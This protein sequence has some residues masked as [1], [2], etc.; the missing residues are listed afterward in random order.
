MNWRA[1]HQFVP[2][3][4]KGDAIGDHVMWIRDHLRTRG[5]DSEIF[6][7]TRHSGTSNET[8]PLDK[9][10]SRLKGTRDS[11]LLYHVA[12]ASPC[13]DFLMSR[14][15]PLALIFHNFTPPELLLGWDPAAAFEIL[16]AQDQLADLVEKARFAIC[17]SAFNAR[18]LLSFGEV[19]CSVI[20]LPV[21]KDSPPRPKPA[22]PVIL[23]VGRIAPN[24][25]I[26]DLISAMKILHERHPDV[27]L[28]IVGGSTSDAYQNAITGLLKALGLE[29]SVSLTGWVT[30]E[31][32]EVEYLRA[33]IFCSLSSHEGFG[34]PLV[35][36]MSQGVP[37]IAHANSAI[38]ETLGNSG[39][40]LTDK[41][42]SVVATALERV[43]LD[44]SL[45]KRLSES[46]LRR[47]KAFTSNQVADAFDEA[48]ELGKPR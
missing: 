5:L 46:G 9:A 47:S 41:S 44:E 28:R 8:H 37:V 25:G 12:Q 26:H 19:P 21:A 11:L 1:V 2:M 27:E 4:A 38:A 33:S 17:D 24:K 3:L 6:V 22:K 23:F 29:E 16:R 43:L 36:S 13:A 31:Q 39:L 45:A 15:E 42:P 32:L 7:G 34:V 48:L 40:L 30:D 18:D 14:D 20:P 35:E 10:D